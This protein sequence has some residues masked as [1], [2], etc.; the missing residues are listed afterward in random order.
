MGFSLLPNE[1]ELGMNATS[2]FSVDGSLGVSLY[3]PGAAIAGVPRYCRKSVEM[4]NGTSMSSPNATGAIGSRHFG[5]H[6][7]SESTTSC[8]SM[9][10]IE[11]A[12]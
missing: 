9:H 12:R 7:D 8:P 3:A 2:H 6:L 5:G 4:M 11:N 10:A 1:L